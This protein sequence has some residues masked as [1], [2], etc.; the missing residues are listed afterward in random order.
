M[1]KTSEEFRH[2]CEV[3]WLICERV[4]RGKLGAP[5][6]RDY[7]ERPAVKLRRPALERDIRLQWALGNRGEWGEWG[8]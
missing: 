2:R 7:L 3:R 6:L 4:R 5:W 8:V 1:D